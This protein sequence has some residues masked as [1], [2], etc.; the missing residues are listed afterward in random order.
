MVAGIRF[1]PSRCR[2]QARAA[3]PLGEHFCWFLLCVTL[4]S[5]LIHAQTTRKPNLILNGTLTRADHETYRV[6]PFAVPVGVKRITVEFSYTGHEQQTTLD[7]GLFGPEGFRGWSGGNK[8]SFTVSAS[9]ATPS[10]LPGPI[11]SGVWKIVIGV[12]NIRQG[13]RSEYTVNIYF[14]LD[15][16]PGG[17][18][19]DFSQAVREGPAWYRGDFH[20]H[21]AHSDGSCKSQNGKSVPCPLFKTLEAACQRK[22][23]FVAVSD[24]NTTS[25]FDSLRELAPYFDGLLLLHAREITTFQGHANVYGTDKFIDFRVS[26]PQV[27]DMN[28][29]LRRVRDVGGITSINHPGAPTGE[30]CM[31]CGW[32]PHPEADFNLITAVEAVNGVQS[33]IP[34]WEAQLN[35]GFRLTAIG[36][37]DSHNTDSMPPGPGAVGTPTTVVYANELSEASILD[38]IRAGHSFIDVEGS[39]DRL[40]EFTATAGAQKAAMGDVLQVAP[41]SYVM[42]TVHVVGLPN[43]RVEIIEDGKPL[44]ISIP[45]PITDHVWSFSIRAD[46]WQHWLRINVRSPEAKLLLVGNPIYLNFQ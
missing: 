5:A 8:S 15:D 19:S 2:R 10:Y 25:H 42:F 41:E 9:D 20:M 44:D 26:S 24:H 33:D 14:D 39:A 43:G 13:V 7:L 38:G 22:L 4:T 6:L 18:A 34:F 28:T 29:V 11:T 21:T 27:P 3:H 17:Q 31:G 36:G 46:R 32:N 37:S 1:H 23:D 30:Q 35:R 16:Q 45:S 12:P 40:L